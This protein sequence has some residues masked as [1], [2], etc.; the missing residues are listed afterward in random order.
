MTKSRTDMR[1]APVPGAVSVF[2]TTS[3][4]TKCQSREIY[5]HNCPIV[6]KFDMY[7]SSIATKTAVKFQ[8]HEMI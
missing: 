8:S 4:H 3:Y 5:I 7:L 1:A 2:E 6:E